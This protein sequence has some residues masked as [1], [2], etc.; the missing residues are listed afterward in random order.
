MLVREWLSSQGASKKT[1]VFFKL[2]LAISA[3]VGG[4]RGA[5]FFVYVVKQT[6]YITNK[7]LRRGVERGAQAFFAEKGP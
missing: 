7:L 4:R 3:C 6:N 5:P 1:G 2:L